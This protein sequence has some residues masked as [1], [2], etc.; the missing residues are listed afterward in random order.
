MAPAFADQPPCHVDAAATGAD[1]G[2]SWQD[3]YPNLQLALQD[4]SC[5][6]IWVAAG[7]YLPDSSDRAA[8]FTLRNNL[9]IYGGF[10]GTETQLSQRDWASNET[11]L[12]GDIGEAG[13]D[14]DNAFNVV[15]A[16]GTDQTARLDGFTITAGNADDEDWDFESECIHSCGGGIRMFEGSPHLA[17][18]TITNNFARWGGGGL[19]AQQNSEPQ[20]ENVH[21]IANSTD[22]LGGGMYLIKSHA[23]LVDVSM[24]GNSASS[25]GGMF[26]D[27]SDPDL[28]NVT[29][30]NNSVSTSGGGIWNFGSNPTLVNVTFSGN[31]AGGGGGMRNSSSSPILRNVTFRN[32][33]AAAFN[34]G[35]GMRNG[36]NSAPRLNNVIMSGSTNGDCVNDSGNLLNWQSSH[37]LFESANSAINCGSQ[38][39]LDNIVGVSAQLEALDDNGGNTRTH[40]LR[41]TSPA[42]GA[43]RNDLCPDVDQRG[44]SRPQGEACDMGAYEF[45]DLLFS[46]RFQSGH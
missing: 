14:S 33:S 45:Q 41:I 38:G 27:D 17:N 21:F 44:L 8:A 13:D 43:G 31:S 11:I 34:G 25:G 7:L 10:A 6:E 28:R 36:L 20:L 35:G 15:I 40:A 4:Q 32:N 37:N 9:A 46:D 26:N 3:A 18:L 42:I 22:S 19:F 24:H 12:S 1:N 30:S 5:S 29:F 39:Y 23:S 16:S 2:S